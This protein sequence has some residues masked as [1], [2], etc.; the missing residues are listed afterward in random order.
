MIGVAVI[1]LEFCSGHALFFVTGQRSILVGLVVEAAAWAVRHGNAEFAVLHF[2]G[3]G[4]S[5]P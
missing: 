4:I 1:N 5:A 2:P 3:A